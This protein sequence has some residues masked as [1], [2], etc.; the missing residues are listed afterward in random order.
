MTS[1]YKIERYFIRPALAMIASFTL[2]ITVAT[3]VVLLWQAAL[4]F[5]S[6]SFSAFF[7]DSVWTPL[8]SDKRYG[9]WPL[10]SGTC[11]TSL[12]ALCVAAPLG[13]I[14]AVYL[15][16]YT[17]TGIFT[18][19]RFVIELFAGIP[20]VVLGYFALTSVTPLLQS[21]FP[22]LPA[23]NALSPGI[24]MGLMI[25]PTVVAVSTDALRAVPKSLREAGSALGASRI[26]VVSRIVVPAAKDGII[27]GILL[28]LARAIGET[29]IV[30]M[31]AGQ[32][33]VLTFNPFSSVE[34]M[35]TY[36]A[37]VSLGDISQD[38]LEYRS[39]FVVAAG[40]FFLTLL[41]NSVVVWLRGP[42]ERNH[43][44]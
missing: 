38:S 27:V 17:T 31:A 23:F 32:Q 28:G 19:V 5:K 6:V 30:T 44:V 15:S 39:I 37:K 1:S 14:L 34:T 2:F 10:L 35:T 26:F 3:V 16:E 42:V 22:T 13:I 29:M 25:L 43:S 18:W 41:V 12:I 33:A 21:I 36:I 9:I 4:F 7:F 40:L 8:F 11:L 20:T 24:V